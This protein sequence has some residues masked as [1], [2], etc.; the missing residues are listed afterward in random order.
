MRSSSEEEEQAAV[1]GELLGEQHLRSGF[2]RQE[3][4]PDTVLIIG[5]T[6]ALVDLAAAPT[7]AAAVLMAAMVEAVAKA[8]AAKAKALLPANSEKPVAR[9]TL[10][11]AAV[12]SLLAAMAAVEAAQL[13]L[14][15][16]TALVNRE[17]PIQAVAVAAIKALATAAL[18]VLALS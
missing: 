8:Q 13:I 16:V 2:P 3:E 10:A 12:A 1:R 6:A 5:T 11:A 7:M 14:A 18:A 17:P 4:T 15:T 9:F